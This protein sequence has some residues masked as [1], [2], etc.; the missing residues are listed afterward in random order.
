MGNTEL[1]ICFILIEL[2]HKKR[3]IL[4]LS[5]YLLCHLIPFSGYD[6]LDKINKSKD[7][8]EDYRA[9]LHNICSFVTAEGGILIRTLV[10]N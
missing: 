8:S 9:N 6:T 2:T 4:Y 10:G 1:V 5:L 7:I 3:P